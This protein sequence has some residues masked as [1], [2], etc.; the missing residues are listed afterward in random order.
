MNRDQFTGGPGTLTWNG[1]TFQLVEDWEAQSE[2]R[3]REVT[4]NLQGLVGKRE[5]DSVTKITAKPIAFTGSLATLFGKLF[6]YSP[7][8]I[9][10]LI[11]PATD[12]P[13]IVQTKDGKSI[14]FAAAAV[15]GMPAVQFTPMKDL[16]GA[17]TLTCIR[18]SGVAA[19]DATS[20]AVVAASAY[21]EPTVDIDDIS[22]ALYNLAW[23]ATSPFDDIETDE[24]GVTF[25]PEVQLSELKTSRD[26]LLNQ[27]VQGV[28]ARLQF[29][30]VNLDADDFYD[31]FLQMDGAAAGRGKLLAARGQQLTVRGDGSGDPL[32]TVPRA[33][34]V[35]GSARFSQSNS[36]VGQVTLEA[37]RYDV[38]GVL[39]S[40]FTLGI[41][42]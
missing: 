20:H 19:S 30:P 41:V 37:H 5:G 13:A 34:P 10:N 9:G 12:L 27:R 40:L 36:R 32:L 14:T 2:I 35:S 23:G 33:V 26:G 21:A 11:Y 16:F 38:A 15:T 39:Q 24:E 3:S 42:A 1:V 31:A 29:T 25:T 17:V 4:T 8:S 7:A 18:K 22:A 28:T 6:P